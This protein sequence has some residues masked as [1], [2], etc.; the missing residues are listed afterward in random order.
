MPMTHCYM[1][2][3]AAEMCAHVIAYLPKKKK[4]MCV[5]GFVC[6]CVCSCNWGHESLLC[7]ASPCC[8]HSPPLVAVTWVF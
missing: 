2:K 3:Q 7:L 8:T 1:K 5:Y 6:V 4:R